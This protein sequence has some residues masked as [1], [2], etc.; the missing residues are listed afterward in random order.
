[1]E[2]KCSVY[3]DQFPEFK[4]KHL[5]KGLRENSNTLEVPGQKWTAYDL[6]H[7]ADWKSQETRL[8]F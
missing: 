5:P 6:A 2:I 4:R 8:C 3:N 1:M 7:S